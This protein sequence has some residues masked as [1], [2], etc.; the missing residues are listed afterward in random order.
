MGSLSHGDRRAKQKKSS[1]VGSRV[2]QVGRTNLRYWFD[3]IW[4]TRRSDAGV[5]GQVRGTMASCCACTARVGIK[6]VF[7]DASASE[8]RAAEE[9]ASDGKRVAAENRQAGRRTDTGF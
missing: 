2:N 4:S 9:R 1:T 7:G 8:Q 3:L 6:G 5:I